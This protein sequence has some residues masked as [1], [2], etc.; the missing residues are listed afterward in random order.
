MDGVVE[1]LLIAFLRDCVRNKL[2][3]LERNEAPDSVPY[4]H[5]T[6]YSII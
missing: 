6:F 5:Y 1:W 3:N 4:A 2:R